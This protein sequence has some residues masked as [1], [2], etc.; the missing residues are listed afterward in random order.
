MGAVYLNHS[1]LK[2]AKPSESK[3]QPAHAGYRG[4]VCWELVR[5]HSLEDGK[6]LPRIGSSGVQLIRLYLLVTYTEATRNKQTGIEYK[7]AERSHR[8]PWGTALTLPHPLLHPQGKH[9]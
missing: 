6:R 2:P 8:N 5:L 7:R 3:D 9:Y 1:W 4:C